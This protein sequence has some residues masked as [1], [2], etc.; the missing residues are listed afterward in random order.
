MVI[1]SSLGAGKPE[2]H[3]MLFLMDILTSPQR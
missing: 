3:K 2:R 1:S